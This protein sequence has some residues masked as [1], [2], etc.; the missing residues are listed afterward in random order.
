MAC[1]ELRNVTFTYPDAD[2]PS[3]KDVSFSLEE[4]DFVLLCGPTGSGKSTLLHL[5]KKEI[6]PTG[7]RKGEIL[8]NGVPVDRLPPGRTVADVGMIFQDPEQ[9]IVMDTVS[10]ELA[11][12]LE[13]LQFSLVEMNK[14]MG[15]L[16]HFFNLEPIL[17]AP[18][19]QLSGGQKQILN[20]ASVLLLKPK[21]LLLDEPTAQ[22]DPLAAKEFLQLVKQMNE[23]FSTTV[24]IS[25]HRLSEAYPLANKVLVMD[26]GQVA[27][28]DE[29]RRVVKDMSTYN[30][31]P[32]TS[33]IPKLCRFCLSLNITS[34]PD[35]LVPLTVREGKRW[36]HSSP[37]TVPSLL[38]LKLETNDKRLDGTLNGT[39]EEKLEPIFTCKDVGFQYSR[40]GPRVIQSLDCQ[41]PEGEIAAVLGGNGAGKSTLLKLLLGLLK[42]QKGRIY[43][44]GQAILKIHERT[45]FQSI[46]YLD[47]N[48]KLVFAFDTVEQVLHYR[49]SQLNLSVSDDKVRSILER[50]QFSSSLFSRHPYDLSGGEQQKLALALLLVADPDVLLLDEPTRGLDP[51]AKDELGKW[52]REW[53]EKKRSII[54]VSHDL[55]FVEEHATCCGLL[56]D[57]RIA[58]FVSPRCFFSGN[59]FYTT[60]VY[61]LLHSLTM[62]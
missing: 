4:G 55:E 47:Q 17:H 3:L 26:K 62:N 45:R 1:L 57:G 34:Q 40:S 35:D 39:E 14:R 51:Q 16:V 28:F 61:R 7:K 29:P 48:P 11:F 31:E 23:E 32:W 54:L 33:F 6:Q 12:A 25:E 9:Q 22:L 13:N 44:R 60:A 52:L 19:H 36:L 30:R 21:I 2:Q 27:W 50:F 5:L 53:Q 38:S 46:A 41:I 24:V 8:L 49:L 18:V 10:Q 59:Y 20:L 56:F 58:E 37:S 42:P 43:Y 15:E